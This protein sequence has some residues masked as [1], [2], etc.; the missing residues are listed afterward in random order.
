MISY[1]KSHFEWLK[2]FL[3]FFCHYLSKNHNYEDN[4]FSNNANPLSFN[5][6]S[7][8]SSYIKVKQFQHVL[9]TPTSF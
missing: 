8:I 1:S 2:F 6:H 3:T 9:N 4:Y 5:F 7:C